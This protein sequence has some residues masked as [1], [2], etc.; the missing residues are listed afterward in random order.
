MHDPFVRSATFKSFVETLSSVPREQRNK[1]FLSAPPDTFRGL[2]IAGPMAW[3]RMESLAAFTDAAHRV[4]GPEGFRRFWTAGTARSL[5]TAPMTSAVNLTLRTF[6]NAP[7]PVLASTPFFFDL[8][9]HRSG[10]L[11]VI[12]GD[13]NDFSVLRMTGVPRAFADCAGYRE[14][15]KH[16]FTFVLQ[17]CQA[18]GEVKVDVDEGKERLD[19]VCRWSEMIRIPR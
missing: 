18:H 10:K 16:A 13:R 8:I 6:R 7:K 1:I 12:D 11:T 14:A 3:S 4:L 5:T 9:S 17:L 2:S 15:W 19:F